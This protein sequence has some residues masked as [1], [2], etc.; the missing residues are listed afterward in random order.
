VSP[1]LIFLHKEIFFAILNENNEV[2]NV[3]LAEAVEFIPEGIDREKAVS[4]EPG[5]LIG[6]GWVYADGVFSD[7]RV[8][9][10]KPAE[11]D[12]VTDTPPLDPIAT[13]APPADPNTAQDEPANA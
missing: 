7:P 12:P 2:V 5:S 13:D 6:V 8:I 11:P 4:I 10:A 1:V 3:V 9:V